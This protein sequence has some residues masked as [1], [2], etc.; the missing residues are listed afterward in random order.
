MILAL[1][2][3]ICLSTLVVSLRQ[4]QF[5]LKR[6]L[7]VPVKKELELP[8]S[9]QSSFSTG[10]KTNGWPVIN[11]TIKHFRRKHL[12]NLRLYSI[13]DWVNKFTQEDEMLRQAQEY[14]HQARLNKLRRTILKAVLVF[15]AVLKD[16][17]I[18]LSITSEKKAFLHIGAVH[19]LTKP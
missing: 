19:R 17:P 11:S 7:C 14:L 1:G 8:S 9:P 4:T 13:F 3:I 10:S 18:L 15:E 6:H 5:S 16:L 2:F 12:N